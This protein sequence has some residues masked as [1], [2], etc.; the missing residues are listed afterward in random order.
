[1][2]FFSTTADAVSGIIVQG[3]KKATVHI[4]AQLEVV[5]LEL[6]DPRLYG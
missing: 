6:L 5:E 1:M 4:I 2:F 3:L